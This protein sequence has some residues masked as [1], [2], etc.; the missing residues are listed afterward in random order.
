MT[1]PFETLEVYQKAMDL[2]RSLP[3]GGGGWEG[4]ADLKKGVISLCQA[5]ICAAGRWNMEQRARDFGHVLDRARGLVPLVEGAAADGGLASPA[6]E[7]F[8]GEIEALCRMISALI[9]RTRELADKDGQPEGGG[10]AAGGPAVSR[11]RPPSPPGR[12][13]TGDHGEH[14][15]RASLH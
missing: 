11:S 3:P 2:Y 13:H 10:S 15:A 5:I 1:F 12:P 4:P 6:R 14:S 9:R 8:R 7:R